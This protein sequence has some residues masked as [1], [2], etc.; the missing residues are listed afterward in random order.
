MDVST[1][2]LYAVV[3]VLAGAAF[4]ISS[5]IAGAYACWWLLEKSRKVPEALLFERQAELETETLK[6]RGEWDVTLSELERL[7]TS[8]TRRQKSIA[9]ATKPSTAE[10]ETPSNDPEFWQL[11][12]DRM[13]AAAS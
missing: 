10:D 11:Q 12:W 1:T 3:S 13:R 5:A 4:L 7:S 2:A 6:L 9:G 8:L